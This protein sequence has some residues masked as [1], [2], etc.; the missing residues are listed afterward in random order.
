VIAVALAAILGYL[1]LRQTA[2]PANDE[3]GV[4]NIDAPNTQASAPTEEEIRV[5]EAVAAGA[6]ASDPNIQYLPTPLIAEYDSLSIHSPISANHITEIEFHQASFSTALQ[7]TPLITVVDAQEVADKHGTNHVPADDQPRGNNPLIAETVSTWRLDS[8]GPEMSSV[9][10]GAVAGTDVYAPVSGTVVKIRS[11][12]LFG[13]IDDFEVHIQSLEHPGLDIVMLH[14][15]DLSI[16]VGDTV[17]GGATRV[18]KVRNIGSVIDNN[19]A[20]FTAQ[21]DPGDHCHVQ[22]NDATR[23]DYQ[24]L[25]DAIDIFRRN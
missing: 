22:V 20:N 25:E 14:I 7:L 21:G 17:Y 6:A 11:Y 19:L 13:L 2:P 9:D 10:V 16:E 18:A 23:E 5:R 24:G 12:S 3:L 4:D 8:V 15:D 1:V